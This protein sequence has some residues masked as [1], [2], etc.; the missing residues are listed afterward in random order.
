MPKE[1]LLGKV[2]NKN[3]IYLHWTK[4]RIFIFSNDYHNWQKVILAEKSYSTQHRNIKLYLFWIATIF[5]KNI[6]FKTNICHH[7]GPGTNAPVERP[8]ATCNGTSTITCNPGYHKWEIRISGKY[9]KTTHPSSSRVI[10]A[11]DLYCY[12]TNASDRTC[13]KLPCYE[14][15]LSVT[16]WLLHD[17]SSVWLRWRMYFSWTNHSLTNRFNNISMSKKLM[18][19]LPHF[20]LVDHF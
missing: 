14:I 10:A 6:L 12:S 11:R 19:K 15:T 8:Q 16:G 4:P 17:A 13:W 1:R 2:T 20:R 5:Q 9:I 18:F 3:K 7:G